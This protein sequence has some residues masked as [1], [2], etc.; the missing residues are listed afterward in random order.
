MLKYNHEL[1][2]LKIDKMEKEILTRQMLYDLVWSVPLLTLSK[3][4]AISDVGLRKICLRMNIPL[5]KPGH[6]QKL[7]FGKKIKK[8]NLDTNFKGD[9][10]V[11][12]ELRTDETKVSSYKPSVEKE[13]QLRIE[14]ELKSLLLVPEKLT[15]PHSLIVAARESLNKRDRWV[16]NGLVNPERGI[17]DIKVASGNIVRSLRFMDTLIKALRGRGHSIEIWNDKTKVLIDG[18]K[19]EIQL[20]E[21]L[22]KEMEKGRYYESTIYVPKGLLSFQINSY[23]NKEWI[24]GNVPIEKLLSKILARLGC[25]CM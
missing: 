1:K 15:N 23:P 4:Y 8:I 10:D 6:W 14:G 25:C 5:P 3:K 19:I 11:S 18:Q 20:R 24:D 9:Q 2:S 22:R 13:L 21:K 17:L 16:H 7:Q 12:L